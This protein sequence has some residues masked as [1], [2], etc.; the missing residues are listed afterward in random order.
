MKARLN[1]KWFSQIYEDFLLAKCDYQTSFLSDLIRKYFISIWNFIENLFVTIYG[2]YNKYILC[3]W[4]FNVQ[5]AKHISVAYQIIA[6]PRT[7]FSGISGGMFKNWRAGSRIKSVA[8]QIV[9]YLNTDL[10]GVSDNCICSASYI[11]LSV[12]LPR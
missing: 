9:A 6:Y 7:E 3:N 11:P 1:I 12:I 10:S 4:L 8:Y 5:T 2:N